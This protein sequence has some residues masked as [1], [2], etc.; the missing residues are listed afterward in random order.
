MKVILLEKIANLGDIGKEVFVKSGY[1][2]NFLIPKS[3]A[4]L[5]TRENLEI[6]KQ[7]QVF[8]KSE[9]LKREIEFNSRAK[10]IS[11]I[12]NIV[13]TARSNVEGKLFG[14]IGTQVISKVITER[15]GFKILKSQI[16]LPN[17]EVLRSIG[18]YQIKV[19]IYDKIFA[20][21]NITVI[22]DSDNNK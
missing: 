22:N 21:L 7:K 2:R 14:S 6:F 11:N 15:V 12:N 8:Q 20:S 16:R 1:A 19:H 17:Q 3:K 4:I 10:I 5:S 18:V 9:I 13:I